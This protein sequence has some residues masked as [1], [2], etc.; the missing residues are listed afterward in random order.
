MTKKINLAND[1]ETF[2]VVIEDR[3]GKSLYVMT[4]A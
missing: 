4:P 2:L 1:V 3:E